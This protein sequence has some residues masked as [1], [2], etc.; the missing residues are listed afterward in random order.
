MKRLI[1]QLAALLILAAMTS[2]NAAAQDPEAITATIRGNISP[3][4]YKAGQTSTITFNRFPTTVEEFKQVRDMIGTEP[5]G[6]IALQLMAFE[7]YRNDRAVGTECIK[8]NNS[9]I[10]VGDVTRRLH[11]LFGSDNNYARPYQVAA[12]LQGATPAN[13]Y[14]PTEPYTIK[15]SVSP[16]KP[17]QETSYYQ[18]KILFIDI[19]MGNGTKRGSLYVVKTS[20]PGE[21]SENSK[22]F[23]IDNSSALHAQVAEKSFTEE[24]KGL[25]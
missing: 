21:P 6:A 1:K 8:L 17:Y 3:T 19:I 4:K 10:N 7:M 25:K 24:F 2:L 5:Q 18:S 9:T 23:I 22:Y 11:E 16:N 12:F 14:N 15:V 20:R 13:G